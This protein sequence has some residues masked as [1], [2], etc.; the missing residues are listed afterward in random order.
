MEISSVI[1]TG[2]ADISSVAALD[3]NILT[4]SNSE[5]VV[6]E[7]EKVL[8]QMM[9]KPFTQS[10]ERMGGKSASMGIN[11]ELLVRNLSDEL[12]QQ[13]HAEFSNQY[14]SNEQKSGE[15]DG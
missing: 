5:D 3:K 9:L 8:M 7:F 10:L 12:F 14:L 1:T 11:F 13:F 4:G 15:N 6:K 2:V